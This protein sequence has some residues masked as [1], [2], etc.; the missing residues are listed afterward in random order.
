MAQGENN[1]ETGAFVTSES[2]HLNR[3]TRARQRRPRRLA[4][5]CHLPYPIKP[6]GQAPSVTR[7]KSR[8]GG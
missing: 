7:R 3:N 4:Q 5:A 6:R 1:C 8:A 2:R